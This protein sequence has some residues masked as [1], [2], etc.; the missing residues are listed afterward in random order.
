MEHRVSSSIKRAQEAYD[1]AL[2]ELDDVRTSI[3]YFR[4]IQSRHNGEAKSS[5]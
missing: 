2:E 1:S 4:E 5:K 3:T